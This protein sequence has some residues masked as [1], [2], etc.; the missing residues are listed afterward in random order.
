M[1]KNFLV[2]FL[3]KWDKKATY[4]IFGDYKLVPYLSEINVKYI[5]DNNSKKWGDIQENGIVIKSPDSIAFEKDNVKV[6][7]AN[8]WSRSISSIKDQLCKLGLKEYTNFVSHKFLLSVW[9]WNYEKKIA[10]AYIEYMITSKCTLNCKNCILFM[11]YYK[12]PRH[13]NIE[14]IQQDID[15]Y[16]NIVDEVHTFRLVGGEPFLHPELKEI[17]NYICKS[18]KKKIKE[19]EIVTN[20][21]VS[22]F[23]KGILSICKEEN[24]KIHVSNYTQNVNY[25]KQLNEFLNMLDSMGLRYENAL[26]EKWSWKKI[27]PPSNSNKLGTV[28]LKELFRDCSTHDRLLMNKKIFFCSM[29]CSALLSGEFNQIEHDDYLDLKHIGK[30]VD[31]FIEFEMGE[32]KKGYIS[33]CKNCRGIGNLNQLYVVP[34]EQVEK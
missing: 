23:D 33:F 21:T 17:L 26:P 19:I 15:A 27:T 1:G 24:I 22:C 4:I 18:Y 16:F 6:I 29:H 31:R 13:I 3:K 2:D 11:P 28:K 20:G 32:I 30:D 12:E 14:V 34:G 5:V 9:K 7:I 25:K 10:E 8:Q